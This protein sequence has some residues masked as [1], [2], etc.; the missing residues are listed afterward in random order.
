MTKIASRVL[1]GVFLFWD[2]VHHPNK[3]IRRTSA[4]SAFEVTPVSG[5]VSESVSG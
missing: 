2:G 3:E 4:S 1:V 5:L